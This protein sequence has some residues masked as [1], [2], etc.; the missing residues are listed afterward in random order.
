MVWRIGRIHSFYRKYEKWRT[1]IKWIAFMLSIIFMFA[2]LVSSN[3]GLSPEIIIVIA[4]SS[5]LLGGLG[6]GLFAIDVSYGLSKAMYSKWKLAYA[7]ED[8]LKREDTVSLQ[9]VGFVQ[10]ALTIILSVVPDSFTQ[11]TP[12]FTIIRILIVSTGVI[13]YTLRAYAYIK[14]SRKMRFFSSYILLALL[15]PVDIY[16]VINILTSNLQLGN[17]A[18]SMSYIIFLTV[19]LYFRYRYIEDK[20]EKDEGIHTIVD[21]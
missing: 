18:F 8:E 16:A 6:S 5:F 20:A 17:M 1:R 19:M 9:A 3:L 10:T 2:L 11:N 12:N 13:F 7:E 4:F 15:V 21:E 14:S